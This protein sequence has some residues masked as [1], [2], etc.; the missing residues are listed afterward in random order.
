MIITTSLTGQLYF[1]FFSLESKYWIALHPGVTKSVCYFTLPLALQHKQRHQP[2]GRQY[3][4]PIHDDASARATVESR[5]GRHLT[6]HL[7]GLRRLERR[8]LQILILSYT[9]AVVARREQHLARRVE[10]FGPELDRAQV[11][12]LRHEV[13]LPEVVDEWG[14]VARRVGEVVLREP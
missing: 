14:E 11:D 13:E 6:R 4:P 7:D 10:G 8:H 1:L 3:L 12:V 2:Q 9:Q 5:H